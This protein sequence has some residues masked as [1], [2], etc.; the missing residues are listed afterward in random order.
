MTNLVEFLKPRLQN[1]GLWVSLFAL[2]P[3]IIQAFG[4][5]VAPEYKEIVNLL[6]SMLVMLGLVNNPTTQT[7]W[8]TDDQEVEQ[9]E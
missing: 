3:L 1:Y 5:S 4:F 9:K 2:I 7:K 6:L 8:F